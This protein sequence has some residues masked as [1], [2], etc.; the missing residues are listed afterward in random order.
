MKSTL[1]SRRWLAEI[2][3]VGYGDEAALFDQRVGA[4]G[5]SMLAKW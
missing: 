3:T 5:P 1:D 2:D 4:E